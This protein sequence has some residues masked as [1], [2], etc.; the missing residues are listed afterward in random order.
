MAV[1]ELLE[2]INGFEWIDITNPSTDELKYISQKYGLHQYTLMDCLEPDHLPK[3]EVLET[4]HFIITRML[5]KGDKERLFTLQEMSTKVAIFFNDLYIITIHRLEQPFL[6]EIKRK[7]VDS[8]R[9]K[10][11]IQLVTNIMWH[12]LHSYEQPGYKLSEQMEFSESNIF[13]KTIT[14]GMLKELYYLKRK[15]STGKKLLTLTV[16]VINPIQHNTTAN[17]A[18]QDVKDLNHKLINMYDQVEEDVQN[19]LNIYLS[20][21]AQK[22][23][24]VVK[25]LTIFSVFFMPL[26]FI[27]GIYG[28]NFEF[29]PELKKRWGYP[30]V[31]AL[32]AIVVV[33]IY[34]WFKRKKWL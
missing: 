6:E 15:A 32:M 11:T 8:G 31:L 1:R 13:L 30:A 27:V 14:P 18:L 20:L 17:S 12:V 4:A 19:L 9:C 33:V 22:T 7:E 23:N 5:I 24:D 28:M 26:T 29:M 21:S 25:I 2:K 10:T 34:A 3:Y 16:D